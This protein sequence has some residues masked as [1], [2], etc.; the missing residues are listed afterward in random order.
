MSECSLCHVCRST[1]ASE[2]SKKANLT[3][4][5]VVWLTSAGPRL[6]PGGGGGED[7]A[8]QAPA[9]LG[10]AAAPAEGGQ[11][12]AGRR[13]HRGRGR[14]YAR[15]SHNPDVVQL[16]ISET[17]IKRFQRIRWWN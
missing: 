3:R 7:P 13:P 14:R 17:D 6:Q 15:L 5:F 11:P 4:P 2:A 12:A 9:R 8:V 16:L 10:A 1:V